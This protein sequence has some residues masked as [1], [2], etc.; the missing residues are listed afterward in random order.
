MN[1]KS[2]IFRQI[3]DIPLEVFSNFRVEP[4]L[5]GTFIFQIYSFKDSMYFKSLT[6]SLLSLLKYS[7]LAQ[8]KVILIICG[9]FYKEQKDFYEIFQKIGIELVYH[10]EFLSKFDILLSNYNLFGRIIF[11]DLDIWL[12]NYYN[13]HSFVEI[14]EDFACANPGVFPKDWN[15]FLEWKTKMTLDDYIFL[16]NK[17]IKNKNLKQ[18]LLNINFDYAKR[19]LGGCI[20]SSSE[21]FYKD[22]KV[23]KI[24]FFLRKEGQTS[25]EMA[26]FLITN[27]FNFSVNHNS[28]QV[29]HSSD[30]SKTKYLSHWTPSFDINLNNIKRLEKLWKK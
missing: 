25:D 13:L 9:D 16:L 26:Y 21:K 10:K 14:K 7:D 12:F 15:Q 2:P 30:L 23:L 11:V 1:W 22:E 20:S 17:I 5:Q 27:L 6:Y 18:W 19:F 8:H 28:I 3:E 29:I 4:K 24:L